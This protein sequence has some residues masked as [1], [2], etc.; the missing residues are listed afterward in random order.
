MKHITAAIGNFDGIH[1]GH[2]EI[3]RNCIEI[4]NHNSQ[5][6]KIITFE[7]EFANISNNAK[8]MK[9]IYGKNGKIGSLRNYSIDDIIFYSLDEDTAK[10]SPE[11][12]ISEVLV[13]KLQIKN[14]VVGFNFRFG[15]K[16]MGDIGLLKYLSK[17][18]DYNVYIIDAIKKDDIV[19]SS[20]IIRTMIE[21]GDIESVNGLLMERY[22]MDIRDHDI[23]TTQRNIIEFGNMNFAYP[24]T[25]NYLV[26]VNDGYQHVKIK[27][28]GTEFLLETENEMNTHLIEFIKKI[29]WNN[30]II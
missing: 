8:R 15:Y 24:P 5:Q 17:K 18:Y 2:D 30:Q 26:F 13:D 21:D 6:K 1:I 14:I 16:A 28:T 7:Y 20:S 11:E 23:N 3:I 9:K 4:G 10:M 12:F 19:V 27:N 22:R 25:G 29:N